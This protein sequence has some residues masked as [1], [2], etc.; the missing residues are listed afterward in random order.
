[1]RAPHAI[2]P[3]PYLKPFYVIS[4]Y[5]C[6]SGDTPKCVFPLP[7][8]SSVVAIPPLRSATQRFFFHRVQ[9]QVLS[10]GHAFPEQF[11]PPPPH[12]SLLQPLLVCSLFH[13]LA[14]PSAPL[15]RTRLIIYFFRAL[16]WDFF[17]MSVS[18]SSFFCSSL[19]LG[20]SLFPFAARY[21]KLVISG[22]LLIFLV[23][24][25]R[26]SNSP[27]FFSYS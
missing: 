23:G 9:T 1:M 25:A 17:P 2:P 20:L 14:T 3:P 6:N 21:H 12:G 19:V 4:L 22:P 27:H 7:D 5:R 10:T 8:H 18:G 15:L 26:S 13:P 16:G 11:C 24:G